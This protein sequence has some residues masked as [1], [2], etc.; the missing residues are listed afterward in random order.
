MPQ[1]AYLTREGL[2]KLQDELT[3]LSTVRRREIAERFQQSRE[4]GGTVSNAEYE[5]AQKRAL[6]Q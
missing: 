1:P 3:Q 5:E 6:F 4:R 2:K